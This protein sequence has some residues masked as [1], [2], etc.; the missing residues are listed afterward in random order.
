MVEKLDGSHYITEKYNRVDKLFE[1]IFKNAYVRCYMYT[2]D[3]AVA[4]LKVP[5]ANSFSIVLSAERLNNIPNRCMKYNDIIDSLYAISI[6]EG[7][8]DIVVSYVMPIGYKSYII[9]KVSLFSR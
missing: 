3:S 1:R 8:G 7:I 5:Y 2:S 4:F 9:N 6:T